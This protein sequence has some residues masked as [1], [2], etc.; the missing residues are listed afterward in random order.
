[1]DISLT[2]SARLLAFAQRLP[3]QGENSLNVNLFVDGIPS[4]SSV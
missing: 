1:M 2:L 3:D 4:A